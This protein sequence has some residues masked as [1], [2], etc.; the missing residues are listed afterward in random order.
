MAR[1]E[2]T[3][4]SKSGRTAIDA[5]F[6]HL[7]SPQKFGTGYLTYVLWAVSPEGHAKNLGELIPGSSDKADLQVTTDL[8]AFGLIVTA[9]PY[10]AVR[11]PSD[12]VVAENQIRPDTIG[13]SEPIAAKYELLPRGQYTITLSEDA[14]LNGPKVSMSRYE[15]TIEVY[16]AQNSV[17]IARAAGAE[18]YAPEVMQKAAIQLS[19]AQELNSRKR[20]NLS[21]IVTAARAAEETAEDARL[22]ALDRQKAEELAAAKQ[23]A[24]A[25]DEAVRKA[26]ADART[27]ETERQKAQE[28]L[29]QERAARQRAEAEAAAAKSQ[30]APPPPQQQPPISERVDPPSPVIPEKKEAR[31]LMMRQLDQA[32]PTLDT[33]RGLVVTIS[34]S[35]F[36]GAALQPSI[37]AALSRIAAILARNPGLSIQVEGHTDAGSAAAEER[38]AYERAFSVRDALIRHGAPAE[39]IQVHGAGSGQPVA[40]NGTLAGRERNRRVE[41]VLAG[42]PIGDMATW[43]KTYSFTPSR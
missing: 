3:V 34:E 36:R 1:G 29:E 6:E 18:K 4:E 2:A 21:D 43:D 10:S 17:Q 23:Q 39:W 24:A 38:L 7:T 30:P 31:A 5:K 22:I 9:E 20:S 27:A 33:P 19:T 35:D 14:G 16:Q 15:S 25:Q 8:Q 11:Q 37:D 41:I 12:V 26:Q 32:L 28:L 13:A 42:A 40:S